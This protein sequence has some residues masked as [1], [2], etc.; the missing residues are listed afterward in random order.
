MMAFRKIIFFLLQLLFNLIS[1]VL[2][3]NSHVTNIRTSCPTK[4]IQLES[5]LTFDI[6]A[7]TLHFTSS[8]YLLTSLQKLIV[9]FNVQYIIQIFDILTLFDLFLNAIKQFYVRRA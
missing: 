9:L 1:S 7:I 8:Q 4:H 2:N 3:V 6:K 5:T